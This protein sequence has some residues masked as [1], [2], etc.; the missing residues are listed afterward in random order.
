MPPMNAADLGLLVL[1]V[2]VGGVFAAHGAQKVFGWWGG[3]GMAG[4][5]M[6]M[7][8]MGLRPPRLWAM[9]SAGT[10]L[11]GGLLFALGA[12]TP[13]V[14][15]LLVAQAIV[16]IVRVHWP[17]G[18]WNKDGGY[19]FPLVLLGGSAAIVGTGPGGLSLDSAV[20]LAATDTIRA[21]LLVLAL[22]GAL[23]AILLRPAPVVPAGTTASQ[24]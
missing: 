22:A 13:L 6:A 19:E 17:K 21:A 4:W 20:G 5:T 1:R 2:I 14:A 18:L 7:G 11:V 23:L 10:E 9:V 3:P 12:V 16:I 8:R 15:A 24:P